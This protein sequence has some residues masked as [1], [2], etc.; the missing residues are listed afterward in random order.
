MQTL[1]WSELR[2][3]GIGEA[4]QMEYDMGLANWTTSP[5]RFD[6]ITKQAKEKSL[7]KYETCL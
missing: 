5:R 4:L 3:R 7:G 1:L 6:I 2:S